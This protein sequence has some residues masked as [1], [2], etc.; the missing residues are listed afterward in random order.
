[1]E[2]I[3]GRKPREI[4][5]LNVNTNMPEIFCNYLQTKYTYSILFEFQKNLFKAF[6]LVFYF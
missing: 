4:I 3:E 1:M 6:I 5:P 2:K